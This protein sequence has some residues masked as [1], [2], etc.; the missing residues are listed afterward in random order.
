MVVSRSNFRTLSVIFASRLCCTAY[1]DAIERLD[2]PKMWQLYVET[3]LVLLD[4]DVIRPRIRVRFYNVCQRALTGKKL[5][6]SH[7]EDWVNLLQI[8]L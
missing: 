4:N 1:E 7:V 5:L 6:A 2:T 3:L 8:A